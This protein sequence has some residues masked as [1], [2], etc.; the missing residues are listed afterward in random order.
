MVA[1]PTPKVPTDVVF[2]PHVLYGGDDAYL[3]EGQ[4]FRPGISGWE[5]FTEEPVEL[6]MIRQS[7]L[8]PHT[9]SHWLGL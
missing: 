4:W 6:A 8:A 2:Y 9:A 3:V 7:T 5:V 1:E